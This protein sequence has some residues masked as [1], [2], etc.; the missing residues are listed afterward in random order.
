MDIMSGLSAAST[1]IGI[2][3]DLRA[4]DRSIDDATFKLKIAELSAALADTQVALSEAKAEL[5]EKDETI[6]GLERIIAELKTG[7]GCPIC[8]TG[9]MKV[10]ASRP[11]PTF[12]NFGLQERTLTCDNPDCSHTEERRHDPSGRT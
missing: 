1:A 2:V 6:R 4:L 8:G 3:K 5:S 12:G 11:H 9:R 7:E 10:T